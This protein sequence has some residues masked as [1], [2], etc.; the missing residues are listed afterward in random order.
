MNLTESEK[1]GVT[2]V[3]SCLDNRLG[4]GVFWIGWYSF[5]SA[6]D[7]GLTGLEVLGKDCYVEKRSSIEKERFPTAEA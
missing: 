1:Q 5:D 7:L 6:L 4:N 2:A 3:P